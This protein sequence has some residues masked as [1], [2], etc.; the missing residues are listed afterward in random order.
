MDSIDLGQSEQSSVYLKIARSLRDRI[1]RGEFGQSGRLPTTRDLCRRLG[2]NRNTIVAA[3]RKLEEWGMARP[4]VG[5]G[6]FAIPAADRVRAA[7]PEQMPSPLPAGEERS[8]VTARS[9]ASPAGTSAPW[10]GVFSRALEGRA[11]A[12]LAATYTVDAA[13]GSISFAGSF[14]APDLMPVDAFRRSM[15]KALKRE[16]LR[17]FSYGAAQGHPA[18]RHWIADE[19]TRSG[20]PTTA[21]EILVTN[22][23]QQAIDLIA[24]A[25]TDPGDLVLLEN[26]TYS[27]AISVFQS[28]GAR[29]AAL[30]LDEEGVLPGSVS[31]PASR[32]G[33]K[34]LYVTPS[35]QNPTSAVMSEQRRRDLLQAAADANLLVVEDDWAF[36]LRFEDPG[37]ASLRSLSRDGRVIYL[38]TFAKKSLPGLRVGWIAA[39][40]P[41]IEKL[42]ALKQI[43]DCCTSPLVQA[44]LAEF[45]R[46]GALA[47]HLPRVREAYRIRRDR[48]ITAIQR[49]FPKDAVFTRPPGGLFLWVRVPEEIDLAGAIVDAERRGVLV[50]RGELFHVDG[51]G[52]N[53]MRLTFASSRPEDIDEGIRILGAAMK[54]H[55]AS[56]S[57]RAGASER[58]VLPLV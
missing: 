30:P 49:W 5:R 21:E 17:A 44:S 11:I 7:A 48:M 50:S 45:C 25:F 13:A 52:R 41:V 1:E 19:M 34:L 15:I 3:Y 40:R 42:S 56:G 8:S 53:T 27:G 23:S 47:S 14:P 37:P 29:L 12:N 10:T 32:G 54:K 28:Y 22:G 6:T 2:V 20:M 55:I 46:S 33:G 4:H 57:R 26:P 36:G 38:S 51:G 58:E 39:A 18:L 31:G 24:R 35:F 16:P 9:S 43:N